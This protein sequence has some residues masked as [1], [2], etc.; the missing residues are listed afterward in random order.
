MLLEWTGTLGWWKAVPGMLTDR[1]KKALDYRWPV[2]HEPWF[3]KVLLFR[4]LYAFVV[5]KNV[6]FSLLSG[7][8]SPFKIW[9]SGDSV[10]VF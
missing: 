6:V 7:G 10:I 9:K 1:I 3:L 4:V 8:A 5:C 2:V